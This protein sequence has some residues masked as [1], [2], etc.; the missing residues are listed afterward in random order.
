MSAFRNLDTWPRRAACG[1][2]EIDGAR[3]WLSLSMAVHRALTDGLYVGPF[4]EQFKAALVD[5]RARL[6][7]EHD[8]DAGLNLAVAPRAGS[9][10]MVDLCRTF[11]GRANTS[12]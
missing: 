2:V 11:H 12:R 4:V 8:G 7:S 6:G 10:T 1:R 5:P 3:Q 9:L